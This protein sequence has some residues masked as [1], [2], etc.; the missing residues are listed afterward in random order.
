L[1]NNRQDENE[2][3]KEV[4]GQKESGE[5]GK[6]EEGTTQAKPDRTLG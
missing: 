4:K 5:K 1:D 2:L 6:S 3:M